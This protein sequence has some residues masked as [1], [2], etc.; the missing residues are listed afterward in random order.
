MD[1]NPIAK[2]RDHGNVTPNILD[3]EKTY[4]AFSWTELET[5]LQGSS[6][7]QGLN[8]ADLA[9]DRHA[10]G[11]RAQQVA[12]R[13]INQDWSIE[14]FTY[15]DLTYQ[16]PKGQTNRFANCLSQLGVQK[17]DRVFALAGRISALYIAALGITS[18]VDTAEFDADRWYRILESQKVTV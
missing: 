18:I 13:F 2:P 5:E 8:I 1:W 16:D 9:I 17:G 15:Q 12:L 7:S 4:R 10:A 6:Q 14:N 3:Y 11:Q